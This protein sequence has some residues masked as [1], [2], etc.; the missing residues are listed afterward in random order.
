M[1]KLKKRKSARKRFLQGLFV[2]LLPRCSQMIGQLFPRLE[3][4]RRW[5]AGRE[6]SAVRRKEDNEEGDEEDDEEKDEKEKR[7]KK[8]KEW[9]ERRS[10][11]N[12]QV[13]SLK[14]RSQNVVVVSE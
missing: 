4:N 14:T 11:S 7:K 2:E 1:R 10:A 9:R 8:N 3:R 13:S 12:S 6:D 5:R